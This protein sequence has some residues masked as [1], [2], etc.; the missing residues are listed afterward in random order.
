MDA[1]RQKSEELLYTY[2]ETVQQNN[3]YIKSLQELVSEYE[4]LSKKIP[5]TSEEQKRLNELQNEIANISPSVVQGYDEQGNAII[6]LRDGVQGLIEELR[7]ANRLK[8]FELVAGGEDAFKV[9]KKDINESQKQL[10]FL[11][12]E[13]EHLQGN[14]DS[15]RSIYISS[16]ADLFWEKNNAG[17][18]Q[19]EEALVRGAI[20]ETKF[21]EI[22]SDLENRMANLDAQAKKLAGDINNAT[23]AFRPYARA[24]LDSSEAFGELDKEQQKFLYNFVSS[25]KDFG[26]SWDEA[27]G[28]MRRL[29]EVVQD[30]SF[31]EFVDDIENLN[32]QLEEGAVDAEKYEEEFNKI[33]EVMAKLLDLDPEFLAEMFKMAIPAIEEAEITLEELNSEFDKATSSFDSLSKA[34]EELEKYGQLS[35]KT[36]MDIVNNH[37]DLIVPMLMGEMNLREALHQRMA[38]LENDAL[39]IFKKAAIAKLETTESFFSEILRGNKEVWEHVSNMYGVDK[40]NF[41][42]VAKAKLEIDKAVREAVGQGWAAMYDGTIESIDA[43][44]SNL[45]SLMG[46]LPGF[47]QAR[48]S[49]RIQNL[50]KLRSALGSISSAMDSAVGK[51]NLG[52]IS[53]KKLD[54]AAKSANKAAKSANKAAKSAAKTAKALKDPY[55]EWRKEAE[56][57]ANEV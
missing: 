52:T 23:D 1:A 22:K 34:A 39:E 15:Q 46:S 2:Q 57:I 35:A 24:I 10:E 12:L 49:A 28:N 13:I 43:M 4:Y 5:R 37:E 32:A 40:N 27:S 11:N 26:S 20:T 16:E 55:E 21:L 42:T 17:L 38:E 36:M 54:S 48:I 53:L 41:T 25:A 31:Q 8:A 3:A 30:V 51:I 14:L 18:K 19:Y 33:I 47:E 56:R 6:R 9:M 7:E 50:K 44:I 45:Q 29:I